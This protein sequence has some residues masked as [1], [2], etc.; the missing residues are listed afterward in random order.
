MKKKAVGAI[1]AH[2]TDTLQIKSGTLLYSDM[3]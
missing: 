3:K 2:N 1:N